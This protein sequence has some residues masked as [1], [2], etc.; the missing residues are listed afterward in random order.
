MHG[1]IA[2]GLALALSAGGAL[3]ATG[4]STPDTAPTSGVVSAAAPV[5]L[6]ISRGSDLVLA[7]PRSAPSGIPTDVQR[8]RSLSCDGVMSFGGVRIGVGCASLDRVAT[9]SSGM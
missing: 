4:L 7:G 3:L 5:V 2:V 8:R 6:A 1:T 9:A